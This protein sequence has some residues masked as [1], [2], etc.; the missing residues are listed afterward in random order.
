MGIV[1]SRITSTSTA[2]FFHT[3]I[4]ENIN[5]HPL[6]WRHND[7]DGVSNHQ[8]HGCLHNRLFGCRSKKTS[9][10]RVTGLCAGNSPGPANSP[11]KGPVTRKCFHLMT[12]SWPVGFP[13]RRTSNTELLCFLR[14]QHEKSC[15]PIQW[16]HNG[17]DG[18]SNHRRLDCLFGRLFSYRSKKILELRA[19][20]DRWIPP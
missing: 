11:H 10:L 6:Q 13:S 18:V 9:K 7:H 15:S 17:R 14:C 16:H 12:S 4:S 19:T 5:V 20:G 8:P 3:N 2:A 1:T